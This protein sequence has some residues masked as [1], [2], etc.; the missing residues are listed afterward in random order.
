MAS[1]RRTWGKPVPTLLGLSDA[2]L[3]RSPLSH[4]HLHHR[5]RATSELKSLNL[6]FLPFPDLDAAVEDDVKFLKATNLV[7]DNVTISGWV[8]EVENGK[9]RRVV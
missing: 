4:L 2:L 9:T 3:L 1:S 6:D 8:Y 5:S 7:P